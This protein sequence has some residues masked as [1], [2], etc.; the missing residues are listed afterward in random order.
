MILRAVYTGDSSSDFCRPEACDWVN[1]SPK[2]STIL[3]RIALLKLKVLRAVYTDDSSRDFSYPGACDWV[4][5]SPKYFTVLYRI[6]LHKWFA[7]QP[8]DRMYQ[9]AKIA[10]VNSTL[11]AV[12]KCDFVLRLASWSMCLTDESV[13][14]KLQPTISG[15]LA[16]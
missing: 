16:A 14:D 11:R 9:E 15:Y 13:E 10:R 12:Y 7:S 8:L 6:A 5:N 1:N 2:Y 4:N 3:Y